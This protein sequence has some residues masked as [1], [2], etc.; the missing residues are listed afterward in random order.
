MAM[1]SEPATLTPGKRRLRMQYAGGIVKHL[2]LSMYRGAV[3]AIAELIANSWDADADWVR[4]SIPLD[5]G[6]KDQEIRVAD[7]G[8]GMSWDDVQ[9]AYLLVGRDRRRAERRERTTGKHRLIMGRKGL[10]KLAG[11][12]IARI[13]EVRTVSSGWLTHFAMD[14]DQMTKG[15][16][17]HLVEDYEP[18]IIEDRATEEPSGTEVVLKE[19]LL[20]RSIPGEDFCASMSRRFAILSEQFHVTINGESLQPF[21]PPLQFRFEGPNDGWEDVPGVGMIRWWVGFTLT[22]IQHASARGVAILV[23]ERMAQAPFFFD[24]SGGAYGQAGMQYMT[25]EVYAEQLD[26]GDRDFIGTDRQGVIWTEPMPEALLKWGEAKVRELLRLWAEKRS[27]QNEKALAETLTGLNETVEERIARLQPVEQ[28]EARQVIQKLAKIESVTDDPDRARELLD[29]VLRAFED[30]SFFALLKA[31][32]ETD[33]AARE[34]VLRL[35][36]ELDVFETI[37][38]AEVVRAR[39]GV[40]RKFQEMIAQDV[41]EKPDMQD[42]LFK[43]PWLIDPEW[44]VV[45]HERGLERLLIEQFNLDPNADPDSERR[46]D[47]FCIGTRGRYL[48]VEVKRPSLT[49]GQKEVVQIMDYVRYLR[50]QAPSSGQA[51]HP[52]HFEG[53]L[54]GH[55]V[56]PEG[57]GWRDMAASSGVTVR[58]W[59]ELLNVAERVHREF[60]DVMKQRAPDDARVRG[61]PPLPDDDLGRGVASPKSPG[62]NRAHEAPGDDG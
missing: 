18:E 46:V 32:S 55:H 53:V 31:L 56:S 61:L 11:F 35:V 25:G 41:P 10:G 39:V 9:N 26:S 60:L 50:Q 24:L 27:A 51:R 45:E 30:S 47:F 49:L 2:G 29:L 13:V 38:M 20:T 8:C 15:G 21:Q 58:S 33:Q 54:I 62:A 44:Q 34:E 4:V 23:R 17:A 12:G 57:L 52:N 36:T 14:F 19:L 48:V 43:H 37:K 3:P 59:R 22:P 16:E 6:L 7:N 1:A 42:F 40:I 28:R 5:T